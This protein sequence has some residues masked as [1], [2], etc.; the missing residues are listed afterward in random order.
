MLDA[1]GSFSAETLARRRRGG[2]AADP[3]DFPGDDADYRALSSAER[4]AAMRRL[5][6]RVFAIKLVH[7]DGKRG[8]SGFPDRLVGGRR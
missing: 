8:H 4:I 6:R 5:S 3:E 7:E 2:R 1:V